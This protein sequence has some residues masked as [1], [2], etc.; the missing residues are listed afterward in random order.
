[1]SPQVRIAMVSPVPIDVELAVV[2][3]RVRHIAIGI[4]G[5]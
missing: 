1:M 5:A 2:P 4:A 3:I